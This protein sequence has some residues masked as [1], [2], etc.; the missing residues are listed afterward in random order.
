VAGKSP[1]GDSARK[2]RCA[3]NPGTEHGEHHW[4]PKQPLLRKCGAAEHGGGVKQQHVSRAF[5]ARMGAVVRASGGK[6]DA[7]RPHQAGKCDKYR[8]R[9]HDL[10][11]ALGL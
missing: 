7:A 4:P 3:R 2:Q 1:N 9:H 5:D 6:D 11:A 10:L 8:K